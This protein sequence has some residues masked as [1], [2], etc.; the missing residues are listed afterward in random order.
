MYQA[1]GADMLSADRTGVTPL[2]LF[3]GEGHLDIVRTVGRPAGY[4]AGLEVKDDRGF[5]PL[6]WA[7]GCGR[8]AVAAWLREQQGVASKG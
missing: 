3:C 4:A 6:D 1:N 5:T 8:Q 2:H 7:V